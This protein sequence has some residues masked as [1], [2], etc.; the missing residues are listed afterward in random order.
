MVQYLK[1]AMSKLVDKSQIDWPD[2]IPLLLM[3]Y[4]GASHATLKHSPSELLYG[5]PIRLP[6]DLATRPPEPNFPIPLKEY[7]AHLKEVLRDLHHDARLNRDLASQAM[8]MR[9]DTNASLTDFKP[10]DKV[11]FF[12]PIRKKG[13]TPK[14]QRPWEHGWVITHKINEVLMRIRKGRK[15]RCV[16]TDRLAADDSAGCPSTGPLLAFLGKVEV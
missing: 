4:R 2:T 10:G 14:L 5:Q 9:Y 8:K 12:N 16:H 6:A 3:A 15:M 11:W 13:L 1:D 7:P